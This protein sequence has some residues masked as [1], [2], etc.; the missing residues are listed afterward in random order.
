MALLN[1]SCIMHYEK[2]GDISRF[3]LKDGVLY[4]TC[5]SKKSGIKRNGVFAESIEDIKACSDGQGHL[6]LF[7]MNMSGDLEI[8]AFGSEKNSRSRIITGD[9]DILLRDFRPYISGKNCELIVSHSKKENRNERMLTKYTIS[10][11]SLITGGCDIDYE[12]KNLMEYET[13]GPVDEMAAVKAENEENTVISVIEK[14]GDANSI[15]LLRSNRFGYVEGLIKIS[16]NNDIF[17]HDIIAAENEI[18]AA[19][20]VRD[21][22][23]FTIKFITYNTKMH[24]L[25]NERTVRKRM[26]CSHPVLVNFMGKIRLCWY[27]NGAVYSCVINEDGICEEPVKWKNSVGKKILRAEFILDDE[28]EKNRLKLYCRK[29][30]IT[31]PE[32][33]VT[34][35]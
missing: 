23:L 12:E 6:Y 17:W 35:F 21:G 26:P 27:E 34:G 2:N 7:C 8:Y 14:N 19:Y 24:T 13:F 32:S 1:Q 20:T 3:I 30:F 11:E 22:G 25:S 18:I 16:M 9:S 5:W 28:E 31:Y 29:V 10:T 33:T 4:I 15:I